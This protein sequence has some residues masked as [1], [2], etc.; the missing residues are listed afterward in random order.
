MVIE[1][2][3]RLGTL[4]SALDPFGSIRPQALLA[5]RLFSCR[6]P[7]RAGLAAGDSTRG[8]LLERQITMIE[9]DFYDELEELG[10]TKDLFTHTRRKQGGQ[11]SNARAAARSKFMTEQD[12]RHTSFDFTYRAARF[13]QGWLLDS[14]GSLYEHQ[15]IRDVL[16]RVKGGKEAN[17]YRCR[18]GAAVDLP[19]T[20]AK[21]Y[22]PRGMRNLKNDHLYREGRPNLDMDGHPLLK[23]RETKAIRNRTEFGRQLL[24]Q[25]WIAHEF[26]TLQLLHAAGADVPQPYASAPNALLMGF[27]G[28][29]SAAPTLSEISLE[30]S[31]ARQLLDRVLNNVDI[32]LSRGVIHGDLS[33]YNIL[34]WEGSITLIDFPQMVRPDRNSSAWSIFRRDVVRV[35][36][37]FAKQGARAD[38]RRMAEDLWKSHGHRIRHEV[39]PLHLDADDPADRDLWDRQQKRS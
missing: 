37:Y 31:E 18:S 33:A 11:P 26:L 13:E 3:S 7:Q 30:P 20:A 1:R 32:M 27:I 25:S 6:E 12:D 4:A 5:L 19:F 39:H 16:A 38:G 29:D 10:Q 22:R 35:C 8:F 21:V 17:V 15:W 2:A 24:H 9:Y 34:Y 36:E 23:E 28:D 14:L